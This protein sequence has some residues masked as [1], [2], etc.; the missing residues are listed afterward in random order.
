VPATQ[1]NGASVRL[2]LYPGPHS[3][4][5]IVEFYKGTHHGGYQQEYARQQHRFD[6]RLHGR[7][8][9]FHHRRQ[10]DAEAVDYERQQLPDIRRQHQ[11]HVDAGFGRHIRLKRFDGFDR[12]QRRNRFHRFHRRKRRC[13]LDYRQTHNRFDRFDR[14]NRFNWLHRLIGIQ[15]AFHWYRFQHHAGTGLDGRFRHGGEGSRR[16]GQDHCA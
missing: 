3:G 2:A 13:G 6:L 8:V 4:C 5:L 7:I 12:F 9:H 11:R 16:R 14:F 1:Q 15:H 10:H